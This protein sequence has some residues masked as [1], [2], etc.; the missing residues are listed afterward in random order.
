[1]ELFKL[2]SST[3][4]VGGPGV[5]GSGNLSAMLPLLAASTP[6]LPSLLSPNAAVK[7]SKSATG[8]SDFPGKGAFFW[9]F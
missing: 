3:I 7:T 1:M 2:I 5:C 9:S 6:N 8:H 4:P